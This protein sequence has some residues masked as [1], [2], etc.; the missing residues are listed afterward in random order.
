MGLA[1]TRPIVITQRESSQKHSH[2]PLLLNNVFLI[3]VHNK[4]SH[5]FISIATERQPSLISLLSWAMITS[6]YTR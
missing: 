5:N 1:L 4:F 6:F 2:Y 3:I